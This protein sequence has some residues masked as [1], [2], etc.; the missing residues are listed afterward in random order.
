[1]FRAVAMPRLWFDLVPGPA[2]ANRMTSANVNFLS[3]I[4]TAVESNADRCL[5]EA[6]RCWL[7]QWTRWRFMRASEV[8]VLVRAPCTDP[9][10]AFRF[11]STPSV[12]HR[13]LEC[14]CSGL[15][16]ND[17]LIRPVINRSFS[18]I[19]LFGFFNYKHL[20]SRLLNHY[21]CSLVSFFWFPTWNSQRI[22][23]ST[24][25]VLF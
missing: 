8:L 14:T 2:I 6:V 22:N 17:H 13:G 21:N 3:T 4:V 19:L 9:V 20:L 1:M 7:W 11:C 10:T 16:I 5:A 12:P 25:D 15:R 23:S 24:V 18:C